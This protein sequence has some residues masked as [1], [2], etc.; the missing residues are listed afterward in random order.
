[1]LPEALA[2]QQPGAGGVWASLIPLLLIFL[3]FYFLLILPQQRRLKQHRRF[4]QELKKGDMVVTSG[5]LHG[6][7]VALD[8]QVVTLEVA[9]R[10]RVRVSREHIAGRSKL[11]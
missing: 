11:R 1:M 5:G 7:I 10:V 8:D 4:L 9:D 6:R 2:A 3:V